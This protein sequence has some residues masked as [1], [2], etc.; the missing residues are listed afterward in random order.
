M[1]DHDLIYRARVLHAPKYG[2]TAHLDL[3]FGVHHSTRIHLSA[4]GRPGWRPVREWLEER[5]GNTLLRI[6]SCGGRSRPRAEVLDGEPPYSYLLREAVVV[7]GDTL[8]V[9]VMFGF[10][11]T[12]STRVRLA[13]LNVEEKNTPRGAEVADWVRSWVEAQG[14]GLV[15]STVKDRRE[16]YG[17]L[18][19]TLHGSDGGPSLNEALLA[20]GMAR[21]YDGGRRS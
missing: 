20:G 8:Q 7:D 14:F 19:A 6:Q 15:M 21:P 11:V 10:G 18:L 1:P 13:G 17:R 16:K 3:G 5:G 4:P 2:A 12:F 9:E